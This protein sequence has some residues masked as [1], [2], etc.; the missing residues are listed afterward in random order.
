MS[1]R[2]NKK[3]LREARGSRQRED[4]GNYWVKVIRK[5]PEGSFKKPTV[6]LVPKDKALKLIKDGETNMQILG[7]SFV[8]QGV[9]STLGLPEAVLETYEAK[10]E[11]V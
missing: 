1:K 4:L 5:V 3:E 2:L 9:L 10:W 7:R 6:Q 11:L 8:L